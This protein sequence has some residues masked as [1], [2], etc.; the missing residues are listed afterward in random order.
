MGRKGG[1]ESSGCV[2]MTALR[3]QEGH[4]GSGLEVVSGAGVEWRVVF[5][6]IAVMRRSWPEITLWD[7]P[8]SRPGFPGREVRFP[9]QTLGH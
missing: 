5:H 2:G 8:W 9:G 3:E 6:G 7:A 1:K 4:K